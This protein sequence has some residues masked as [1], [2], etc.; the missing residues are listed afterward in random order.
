MG[1]FNRSFK[2]QSEQAANNCW[3]IHGK[4][5]QQRIR[6]SANASGSRETS[7]TGMGLIDKDHISGDALSHGSRLFRTSCHQMHR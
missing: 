3:L 5:Q 7:T 2:L 4:P 1:K 6:P